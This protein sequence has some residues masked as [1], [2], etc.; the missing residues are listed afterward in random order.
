MRKELVFCIW[1]LKSSNRVYNEWVGYI[2]HFQ[3]QN[4]GIPSIFKVFDRIDFKIGSEENNLCMNQ[5]RCLTCFDN[6]YYVSSLIFCLFFFGFPLNNK[7]GRQTDYF[8]SPCG[9]KFFNSWIMA[10]VAC[11]LVRCKS[12]LMCTPPCTGTLLPI[13]QT[14]RI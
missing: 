5:N 10:F 13:H 8:Q 14:C 2:A 4:L 7:Q 6:S 3:F 12:Y 9:D 1:F 11:A